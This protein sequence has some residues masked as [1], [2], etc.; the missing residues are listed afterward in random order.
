MVLSPLLLMLVNRYAQRF[1]Q[2]GNK[3]KVKEVRK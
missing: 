1:G 2:F 3:E